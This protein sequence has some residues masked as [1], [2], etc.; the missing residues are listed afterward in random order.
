M[1]ALE[2][3][4]IL[5]PEDRTRLGLA[6]RSPK[7]EVTVAAKHQEVLDMW[8]DENPFGPG[9]IPATSPVK[10]R[11]VC[12]KGHR[13][14]ESAVVQCGAV[15]GWRRASGGSR[16][17]LAC[18]GEQLHGLVT[19][20]CGHEVIGR[21]GAGS[22]AMCRACYLGS[23]PGFSAGR[24]RNSVSRYPAGTVI[25]SR[26]L[27]TSKTEL[28]V[29]DKL[30]AAGFMLHKGR[31][32]IQCGLEPRRG[33]FPVLT[34][35]I[36]IS[37]TKV[38]IEVDPAY[39]HAGKEETDQLRN[40]L[41]GGVGWKVIRLRLGGLGAIGEHDVLVESEAVTKEAMEALVLAVT[42][43]VAGRAG[44]IRE[45]RKKEPTT[46]RKQSRL[47]AIAEHKY[48]ENA[49]YISWKLGSGEVLRM[50]AMDSGRYLGISQGWGAPRFIRMLGLDEVPRQQWRGTVQPILESMSDADFTPVSTFPW[51]DELFMGEQ[52]HQVGISP[53][54]H[55]GAGLW[56][57][58]AN[59][60]GA[61]T[62]SDIAVY[63]GKKVLIK[64]HPEAVECGWRI[65][66]MEP[67]TGRHGTYQEIRLLRRP[68]PAD[69]AE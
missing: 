15:S 50:V 24:A 22:M 61:E 4:L 38:C 55:L 17:C 56:D 36:L 63:D 18:L 62:H 7:P 41:L 47:G 69:A 67:R 21:P 45:V 27:S 65:D 40:D 49:F 66:A 8:G 29:R 2:D 23:M 20:A 31:S 42:D 1:K 12:P 58:T 48:Y 30:I 46:P 44:T 39:T 60:E 34:P 11:W 19:L 68:L 33:N 32:A 53:K 59:L 9:D 16:T 54:F 25:Q 35:D 13:F 5:T 52:A 57:L 26:N 6:R 3:W 43:A 37:R 14:I 10:V 51:G 64:L 28:Q